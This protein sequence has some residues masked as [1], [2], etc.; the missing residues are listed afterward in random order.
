MQ[1]VLATDSVELIVS[2][3]EERPM[4]VGFR[5]VGIDATSQQRFLGEAAATGKSRRRLVEA[6]SNREH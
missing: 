2:G 6:V 5:V 4:D 1:S 3:G